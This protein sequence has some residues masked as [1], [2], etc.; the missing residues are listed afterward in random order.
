MS[1][2]PDK[3]AP[4]SLW[5][6]IVIPLLSGGALGLALVLGTHHR[7]SRSHDSS[8]SSGTTP[9][10]SLPRFKFSSPSLPPAPGPSSFGTRAEIGTRGDPGNPG[11]VFHGA[12]PSDTET[13]ER[14]IGAR[15]A[16]FSGY[17]TWV[18][19]VTRVSAPSL[20]DGYAGDYLKV[21]VTVFNRDTE[22][23]HVCACDFSVWSATEG[24][25]EADVVPAKSL[26]PYTKMQSGQTLNG[27]VYLYVGK[28]AGPLFVVYHPDDH[29]LFASSESTGVWRVA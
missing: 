17:T 27:D 28:A 8:A 3:S 26:A 5:L 10:S 2:S 15:P 14:T 9:T 20:V 4:R 12:F 21:R 19:S 7:S 29:V 13:Q 16:R 18:R 22:E 6:L 23:Q 24:Q 1:R 11:E 25:R